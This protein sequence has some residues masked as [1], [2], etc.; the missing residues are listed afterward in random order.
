MWFL[1]HIKSFTEWGI[2]SA[3][4]VSAEQQAQGGRY[5]VARVRLKSSALWLFGKNPTTTP[6]CPLSEWN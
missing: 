3:E 6:P 4:H 5:V 1:A 2:K